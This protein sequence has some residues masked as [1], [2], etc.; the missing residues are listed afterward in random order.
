MVNLEVKVENSNG[1]GITGIRVICRVKNTNPINPFAASN[2]NL[3]MPDTNSQ[4]ISEDSNV[5][6]Y[7]SFACTANPDSA[8][9]Q[10][11]SASGTTST[12]DLN[13][14]YM[15]LMLKQIVSPIPT[16][17][18]GTLTCPSGYTL[19]GSQCIEGAVTESS[20][21][22]ISAWISS[23]TIDFALLSVGLVAFAIIVFK[24]TSKSKSKSKVE[25]ME[26]G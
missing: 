11:T 15:V 14:G 8:A 13:G 16:G 18:S 6:G 12:T 2:Y 17:V 10:Y 23:H 9:P 1:T 20:L 5:Q 26:L 7:A 4:G 24:F 25:V 21:S 19:S 22:S 3:A